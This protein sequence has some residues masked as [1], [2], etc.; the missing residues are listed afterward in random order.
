MKRCV[1][2]ISVVEHEEH[3]VELGCPRLPPLHWGV[4]LL[5]HKE[6]NAKLT[7]VLLCRSSI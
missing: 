4:F 5:K 1:F 6:K 7:V 3:L 2:L